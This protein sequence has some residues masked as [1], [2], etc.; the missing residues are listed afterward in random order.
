MALTLLWE[1]LVVTAAAKGR[2]GVDVLWAAQDHGPHAVCNDAM[3]CA[4]LVLLPLL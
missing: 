3:Q 2:V 1:V 4:L